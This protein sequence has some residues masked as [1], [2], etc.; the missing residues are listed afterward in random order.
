MATAVIYNSFRTRQ[1]NGNAINFTSDTIKVALLTSSYTPSVSAHVFFSDLTNEV[2]G[3]GY[4]TGG[5]ALTGL[6]VNQDNVGNDTTVAASNPSWASST[7]TARYAA[8]YKS[9]GTAGTSALIGYIDFGGNK[10]TNG[11]T[12]L[13]QLAAAGLLELA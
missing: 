5:V 12:F 1:L 2:V 10:T 11:D 8:V 13:I 7:I 6:A 4:T 3:A 9:T